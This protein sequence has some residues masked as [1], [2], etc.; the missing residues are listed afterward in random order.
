MCRVILLSALPVFSVYLFVLNR[1]A[2]KTPGTH[3]AQVS[4][5]VSAKAPH[6]L[7]MTAMGGQI[8]AARARRHDMGRTFSV[9]ELN[10]KWAFHIT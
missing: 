6:P 5:V 9:V 3:P 7:S 10:N 4:R 8:T 1:M 2:A